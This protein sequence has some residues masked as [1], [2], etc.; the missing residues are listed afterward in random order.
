MGEQYNH[1]KAVLES[2][3]DALAIHEI[4]Q[5]IWRRY[6]VRHADTAISA[7]IRDIRNDLE[8]DGKT[9]FSHRASE[10]AH[11]HVYYIGGLSDCG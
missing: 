4:G 11:H 9:I 8:A 6:Q 7:R 1:V 2:S 10:T 3:S 5:E